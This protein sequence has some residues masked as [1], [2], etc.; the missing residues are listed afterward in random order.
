MQRSCKCSTFF[1]VS[2]FEN[3]CSYLLLLFLVKL[4]SHFL[5]LLWP[6][7]PILCFQ[8]VFISYVGHNSNHKNSAAYSHL[9]Y[10]LMAAEVRS[11]KRL[12]RDY[13][14]SHGGPR[15]SLEAPVG[16]PFSCL[17]SSLIC[18]P[19]SLA[20][21]PVLSPEPRLLCLSAFLPESH[22]PLTP[23]SP[24]VHPVVTLVTSR[25]SIISLF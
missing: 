16:N 5:L 21:D 7:T 15:S 22:L 11:L 25:F 20:G 13:N 9:V 18:R 10:Y 24:L 19:G 1:W 2:N 14:H 17:L 4:A 23:S 12:S 8:F 3:R 6:C